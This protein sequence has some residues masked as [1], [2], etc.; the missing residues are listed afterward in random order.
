MIDTAPTV[1]SI[2]LIRAA[3]TSQHVP[4]LLAGHETHEPALKFAAQL[5]AHADADERIHSVVAA[6]LPENY[7]GD[8]LKE[9]PGMITSARRKGFSDHPGSSEF[10]MTERGLFH[11]KQKGNV[12]ISV[13]V[14]GT[15]EIRGLARDGKSSGWSR[16]LRWK[17]VDGGEHKYLASDRTLLTDPT[18]YAATWL[19]TG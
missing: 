6:A 11:L 13:F 19:T 2:S 8:T 10:L 3:L 5:V 1:A 7:S 18:L 15:F 4:Q 17:D 16:Y 12:S 14:S 9:L